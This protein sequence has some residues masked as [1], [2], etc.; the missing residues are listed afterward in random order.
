MNRILTILELK[1]RSGKDKKLREFIDSKNILTIDELNLIASNFERKGELITYDLIWSLLLNSPKIDSLKNFCIQGIEENL[2]TKF[3]DF[4]AWDINFYISKWVFQYLI[5]LYPSKLDEY[6]EKYYNI[7]TNN[8][9]K[10]SIA[11]CVFVQNKEFGLQLMIDILPFVNYDHETW[12][13]IGQYVCYEGTQNTI[14]YLKQKEEKEKDIP[15]KNYYM[16]IIRE[17]EKNKNSR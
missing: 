15:M 16:D 6:F 10:L 12:S 17:L 8:N 11:E 13:S 5:Y 3:E 2:K 9:L 4:E 14:I 7:A 1:T